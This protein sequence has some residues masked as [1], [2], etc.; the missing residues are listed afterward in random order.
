MRSL[1][2]FNSN[3]YLVKD[4]GST[5]IE[6]NSKKIDY[7]WGYILE[8]LHPLIPIGIISPE[9]LQ[10]F[11]KSTNPDLHIW[12]PESV[13][14]Y[15]RNYEEILHPYHLRR[16]S[17]VIM[18]SI[19]DEWKEQLNSTPYYDLTGKKVLMAHIP[20][21]S[22]YWAPPHY[23]QYSTLIGEEQVQID[24][25][26]FKCYKFQTYRF[27][28]GRGEITPYDEFGEIFIDKKTFIPIKEVAYQNKLKVVTQVSPQ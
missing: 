1:G 7:D 14:V 6:L 15:S 8:T 25:S 16:D 17:S 23:K 24:S 13:L 20:I 26:E 22:S 4:S 19:Y 27:I 3:I 10:P 9:N 5:I 11:N 18:L 12:Y 21:M 2:G 28:W